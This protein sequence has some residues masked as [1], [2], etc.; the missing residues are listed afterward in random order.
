MACSYGAEQGRSDLREALCARYYAAHGRSADE[1]FVSDGS[2]CDIG[3]MQVKP[4]LRT[5][6][7]ALLSHGLVPD[8][9]LTAAQRPCVVS[10]CR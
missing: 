2:K 6:V 9:S 10:V 3:R 4:D 8:S 1:I 5:A 7:L